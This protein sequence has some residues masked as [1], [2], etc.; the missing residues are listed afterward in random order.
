MPRRQEETQIKDVT[1]AVKEI[2]WRLAA[3]VDSLIKI[4]DNMQL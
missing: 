4:P 2:K 3:H 1:H